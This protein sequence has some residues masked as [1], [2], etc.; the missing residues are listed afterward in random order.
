MRRVIIVHGWEGYPTEGWFP[1]MKT[2]LET[3][4]FVVDVP[5]MDPADAPSIAAWVPQLARI[6]GEP[7]PDTYLVGHSAGCITILRY[8]ETLPAGQAV[9]GVVLVAGFTDALGYAELANYFTT[10][11]PWEHIRERSVG[12]FVAIHSDNDRY[13]P[14]AHGDTFKERLGAAVIVL[15]ER[16]HFSGGDG[17]VELPEARDAVLRLAGM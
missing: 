3:E 13:V 11:L 7:T 2:E 14:L 8:L 16:Q 5:A 10:P 6:V 9:G 4:G 12:G 17:C 1:W 15:H